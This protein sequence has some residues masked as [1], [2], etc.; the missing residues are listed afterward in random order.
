MV[1]QDVGRF[2]VAVHD[3]GVVHR[4]YGEQDL[5][6]KILTAAVKIRLVENMNKIV[7]D[8]EAYFAMVLAEVLCPYDVMQIRLHEFLD[9]LTEP[10][11]IYAQSKS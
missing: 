6:G 1:E 7:R 5:V 10:I 8:G 4:L 2:Q 9:D 3:V 11:K